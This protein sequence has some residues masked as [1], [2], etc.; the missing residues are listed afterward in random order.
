MIFFGWLIYNNAVA[1]QQFV[2]NPTSGQLTPP[3][4]VDM[5]Q[6]IYVELGGS[7][8]NFTIQ[9]LANGINLNRLVHFGNFSFT[10]K[11]NIS[12]DG[13]I[14]VSALILD[15]KGMKLINLI[16]NGWEAPNP[17]E[18]NLQLWDKNYNSYALE[19]IDS[20]KIPILQVINGAKN[21]I[22]IGVCLYHEGIPYFGT[23]MTGF[24]YFGDYYKNGLTSDELEALRNA[25]IF[26]YPSSQHLGQLKTIPDYSTNPPSFHSFPENNPLDQSTFN[27]YIGAIMVL[28]GGLIDVFV[29][30]DT[31]TQKN[32]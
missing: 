3:Y 12:K 21:K 31:V 1:Q 6:S 13:N 17:G 5:T 15:D 10:I 16:N 9:E 4:K 29:T 26:Y 2:L 8:N 14:Q 23:I 19:I 11:I 7:G 28:I 30:L 20:N 25:T 32:K 22:F 24:N 27:Q 18:N